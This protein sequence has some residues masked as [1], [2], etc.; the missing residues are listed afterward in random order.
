MAALLQD[1]LAELKHALEELDRNYEDES[2]EIHDLLITERETLD[3][4]EKEWKVCFHFEEGLLLDAALRHEMRDINDRMFDLNMEWTM[5]CRNYDAERSALC[6]EITKAEHQLKLHAVHL[7][8][9]EKMT[10]VAA[11]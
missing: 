6:E 8:F 11:D 9:C 5:L 1:K 3:E 2:S 4:V 10:A 7:E